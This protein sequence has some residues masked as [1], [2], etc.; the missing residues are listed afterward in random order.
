[1]VGQV[2]WKDN[3]N[4]G[5]NHFQLVQHSFNDQHSLKLSI[6]IQKGYN[7]YIVAMDTNHQ[8]FKI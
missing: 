7:M 3:D 6:F 2:L 1:M 5:E 4:L 8:L